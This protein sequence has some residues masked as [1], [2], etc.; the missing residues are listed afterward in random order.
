[1]RFGQFR[2]DRERLVLFHAHEAV[3]L[4]PKSV[5]LLADLAARP[6]STVTKRELLDRLWPESAVEEANLSQHV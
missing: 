6:G 4:P 2:I 1:M 3:N 5:E